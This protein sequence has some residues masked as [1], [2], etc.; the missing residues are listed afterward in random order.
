M[1]PASLSEFANTPVLQVLHLED[2][3]E[4]CELVQTT[5]KASGL[6]CEF[7]HVD[8]REDYVRALGRRK[9]DVILADYSIPGY[10]GVAALAQCR[11]LQP[12]TPFILVSG[13]TGEE[14]AI[15]IL[16]EGATDYVLKGRM[17]RLVPSIQRAVL[18]SREREKHRQ[19][20]EALRQSEERFREMA[21]NIREMFWSA[22][23]D[24]QQ[25]FYA[26]R[27]CEQIWK[28]PLVQLYARPAR[29]LEQTWAE[30]KPRVINARK[31]LAQGKA[32]N[33]EYRI[34]QP[35]GT[36]RWIEEHGY[37]VP[38][39]HGQVERM[40]GVAHDI[41]DRKQLEE[42]LQQAQKIDAIGQLAGGI[43]HDFSNVLT[44]INGYSNLLLDNHVLPPAVAESLKHIYVAGGRAANLTR[45]LLIFSRKSFAQ[46]Q[47]IDLNEVIDVVTAMLKRMIGEHIKLELDLAH[48]LPRIFADA[49][50]IEQVLMNLV[51]NARDAMPKGGNLVINTGSSEFT[52][53]DCTRNPQAQ[54]GA[55]AWLSVQ[56][57]GCGIPADVLPRIFEPFF[58]TK[59]EGKGTGLGLA[60]VMSIAKQHNGWVEVESEAGLGTLFRVYVPIA[61]EQS[62][63]TPASPETLR[64]Q[65]GK[66]VILLVEDDEPVRAYARTVLQ[67][68]GY[69]VLEAIS[70]V[71]ALDVWKRHRGRISLLLTDLVMPDEMTGLELAEKLRAD[72]PE[73]KVL[74]SS[75][76]NPEIAEDILKSENGFSFLHKPY[77]PKTLARMVREILDKGTVTPTTPSQTPFG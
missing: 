28:I 33:L 71:E 60:T 73:L 72:K 66:E 53:A 13:A 48:P 52:A 49:S 37:P 43:A 41:T 54:P 22:S 70:G 5:V 21:D 74:F 27:A 10:D 4:D 69:K 56:D 7:T 23:A 42:Q 44:V 59:E 11:E 67:M 63:D 76:Y 25:I 38:G 75:G 19:M 26:S 17:S 1:K 16:K 35:D 32:Y 65:G 46:H 20:E 30:D 77:Q 45:Q 55:Y 15:E 8:N 34:L 12:T 29:W 2:K 14:R 58:T 51:V 3:P 62:T 36:C 6:V 61:P 9:F 18:E 57:T 47:S 39:P 64:V 40:V 24:G 68:H 31:S 50:M